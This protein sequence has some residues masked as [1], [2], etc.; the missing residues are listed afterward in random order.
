MYD[1]GL[2]SGKT[3]FRQQGERLKTLEILT[4]AERPVPWYVMTSAATDEAT[5]AYF[6][7]EDYF[8]LDP[9]QVFFFEQAVAPAYLDG[10]RIALDAKYSMAVA[11]NGIKPPRLQNRMNMNKEQR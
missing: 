3:L 11:P 8:G 9:S 7:A 2:P 10:G 5:R 1:I 6:D 4:F